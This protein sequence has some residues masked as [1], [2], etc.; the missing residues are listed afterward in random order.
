MRKWMLL[1]LC[2]LWFFPVAVC[3]GKEKL[4]IY[5]WTEYLPQEIIQEFE[6]ETGITVVYSTYE[7]N[8]AMY[9]KIRLMGG[10]GYD[11]IFP[12]TYFVHKMRKQG[13]LAKIDHSRLPNFKY[14]DPRFLDKPYDP[15]NMYSIPYIWGST[16][17]IFNKDHVKPENMTSWKDLWRPEFRNR[18]VM[19]DDLREVLGMGLM[20]NGYSINDTDPSHIEKAY[21][22]IRKLLPNILVFSGDSPKQ[23][24]LNLETW[25]GMSW[26]GE[27][28]MAHQENPAI[29]YAYPKEGAIFWLDSMAIPKKARNVHA[30][31]KFINFI[32][33]PES[34]VRICKELGFSLPNA[35]AKKIMP[36]SLANN[37]MIFP[38]EADVE[39]GEFQMDVGDAILVYER[40]WERLKTGL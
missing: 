12:S 7:N 16:G 8:E 39:K 32:L 1:L 18:L 31:H 34:A 21:E 38:S 4:Y 28:Y 9:A 30:A 15:G 23:P 2:A 24:M 27:A 40:F 19:N 25:A 13:L 17:L 37:P 10:R 5:N 36:P 11:L 20:V 22:S 6:R 26:N 3:T 14:L 35:A 29:S 33:K